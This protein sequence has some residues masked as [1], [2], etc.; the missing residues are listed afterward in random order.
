MKATAKAAFDELWAFIEAY[1][2][3]VFIPATPLKRLTQ[4]SFKR[5]YALRLLEHQAQINPPW[6]T[7]KSGAFCLHLQESLSDFCQAFIMA[8]QGFYKPAYLSLRSAVENFFRCIGLAQD[9]AVLGMSSVFELIEIV[10][11]TSLPKTD[12]MGKKYVDALH[13]EYKN[14]CGYVHTATAAHMALTTLA[15]SFPR[16][17]AVD[18]VPCFASLGKVS[19]RMLGILCLLL[20]ATFRN[21]H[22]I[23]FDIVCDALPATAKRHILA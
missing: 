5:F 12:K 7:A 21:L 9:Q 11:E 18:A 22:H 17:I 8:V 3:G 2:L 23:H 10:K 14:L 16:F 1:Q 20:P 15:G 6:D 19:E 13:N 4:Q